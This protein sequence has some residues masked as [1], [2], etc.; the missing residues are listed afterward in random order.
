MATLLLAVCV[1]AGA[2]Y[3]L[4][5]WKKAPVED[6][7]LHLDVSEYKLDFNHPLPYADMQKTWTV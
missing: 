1:P 5:E 6:G 2:Q 7:V 3:T 4:A